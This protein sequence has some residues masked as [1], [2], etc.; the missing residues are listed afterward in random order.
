MERCD[1]KGNG[2]TCSVLRGI[3]QC[4]R[5]KAGDQK[6]CND[7]SDCPSFCQGADLAISDSCTGGRCGADLEASKR[8]SE[9]GEGYVCS[10]FKGIAACRRPKDGAL[11][12]CNDASDCTTACL[13]DNIALRKTCTDG[14]CANLDTSDYCDRYGE[15][16]TCSVVNRIAACRRPRT[17]GISQECNTSEECTSFCRGE[18]LLEKMSCQDGRCGVDTQVSERCS[19]R[20]EGFRCFSFNNVPACRGPIR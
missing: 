3:A 12:E 2:W 5:P 10:V 8:C 7:G 14:R 19:E 11:E 1:E 18:E 16:W 13:S 17:T 9:I 6:E 4:R 20:G 15:G